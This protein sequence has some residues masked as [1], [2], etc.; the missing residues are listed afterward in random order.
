MP[1]E[2]RAIVSVD[3]QDGLGAGDGETVG[4]HSA[5]KMARRGDMLS[6]LMTEFDLVATNTFSRGQWGQA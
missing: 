2:C 5:T 3:A 4:Q 1:I 6:D